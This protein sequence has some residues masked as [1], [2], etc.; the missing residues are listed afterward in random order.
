MEKLDCDRS[1]WQGIIL[2]DGR[3]RWDA[4]L[5]LELFQ[6]ELRRARPA[7]SSSQVFSD[8][9][10]LVP[11]RAALLLAMLP[12][13]LESRVRYEILL[14]DLSVP[15]SRSHKYRARFGSEIELMADCI[16]F[17]TD[18][19]RHTGVSPPMV[20]GTLDAFLGV[21]SY[22]FNKHLSVMVHA[23]S[24]RVI[25]Q[26][27]EPAKITVFEAE[28]HGTNYVLWSDSLTQANELILRHG[29]TEDVINAGARQAKN[30]CSLCFSSFDIS[31]L[32]SQ[33]RKHR[34][35][36]SSSYINGSNKLSR[37]NAVPTFEM[38]QSSSQ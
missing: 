38:R 13:F 2:F 6:L 7:H 12:L 28:K 9:R 17:R 21:A 5:E 35:D 26:V 22:S 3:D 23:K 30:D 33:A 4:S 1:Y 34:R 32:D 31:R 20:G 25:G 24:L 19:T 36:R 15:L 18:I 37:L 10:S 8:A 27:L 14:P 29:L 11:A 16:T